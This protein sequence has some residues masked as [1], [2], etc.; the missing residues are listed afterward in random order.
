MTSSR[1]ARCGTTF[2]G[3]NAR[4]ALG[5][6]A[7]AD[8]IGSFTPASSELRAVGRVLIPRTTLPVRNGSCLPPLSRWRG[9]TDL[10]NQRGFSV[11]FPPTFRCSG[12]GSSLTLRPRSSFR[13]REPR[14]WTCRSCAS[15]SSSVGPAFLF[16]FSPWHH[17][18]IPESR[19]RLPL[20]FT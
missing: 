12:Q 3:R 10:R 17:V 9:S 4:P 20:G 2:R 8:P 15:F 11:W 14:R 5:C 19:L 13:T 1:T 7:G 18:L 6:R 16:S